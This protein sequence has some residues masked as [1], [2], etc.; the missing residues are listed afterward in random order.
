MN[1]KKL[2]LNQLRQNHH[3]CSIF[4][5]SAP[6]FIFVL[7]TSFLNRLTQRY[8]APEPNMPCILLC[9]SPRIRARPLKREK[10]TSQMF[11]TLT[12][13]TGKP[14]KFCR[15]FFA[16]YV[17]ERYMFHILT[18]LL[19]DHFSLIT[20]ERYMFRAAKDR[21]SESEIRSFGR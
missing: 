9:L 21:L 4:T 11:K 13:P 3:F 6:F 2:N 12:I 10:S 1:K 15:D 5:F 20:S 7:K 14:Q 18:I 16:F 19:T 17:S 8:R